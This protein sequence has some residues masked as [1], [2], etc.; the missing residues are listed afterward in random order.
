M[1]QTFK[2]KPDSAASELRMDRAY[3]HSIG[4]KT[5]LGRVSTRREK[6]AFAKAERGIS[7]S[8]RVERRTIR[9]WIMSLQL[10]A[11]SSIFPG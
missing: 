2:A 6:K 10:E 3:F 4:E 9:F 1:A 8:G 7:A 5:P 11:E